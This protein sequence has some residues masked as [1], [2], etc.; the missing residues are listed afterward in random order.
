[1]E[2]DLR[3]VLRCKKQEKA[4]AL[5]QSRKQRG[6]GVYSF[7]LRWTNPKFSG[8]RAFLVAQWKALFK[9]MMERVPEQ[10]RYYEMVR[11]E[12]ACKLYFDLEFNKLLNP[13]VN[14]DS[15]TVKFVDFV[16]AQ[17]TS[18]TGI[19]VA[20]ED[21]LILKSDSDRKYSAHLIVNVDEICFRNNQ[22]CKLFVDFIMASEQSRIF[23]VNTENE[24]KIFFCDMSV[25]SRNRNFRLYKNTKYKKN[26]FLTVAEVDRYVKSH[27][28]TSDEDIF[29]HSLIC[30]DSTEGKRILSD[31]IILTVK[32]T[33]HPKVQSNVFDDLAALFGQV[34]IEPNITERDR[35]MILRTPTPFCRLDKLMAEKVAPYGGRVQ[36]VVHYR[37]T[38]VLLYSFIGYNFCKN[39]GR[40]HRSNKV[41]FHVDLTLPG[42]AQKC[43]D[44]QDC[45][46]YM[47]AFEPI[48]K[49]VAD[50]SLQI[51]KKLESDTKTAGSE[52]SL[53]ENVA[54][55][56]QLVECGTTAKSN[57]EKCLVVDIK[58]RS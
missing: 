5:F 28:L 55:G 58:G 31:D 50:E 57:D 36:K 26:S 37:N 41:Y 35:R 22:V 20:Y 6:E 43:F 34:A 19:N 12:A 14:G 49:I 3:A 44:Y 21:V 8:C 27:G 38:N 32:K 30:L 53:I 48:P 46:G 15:L 18:L 47:S 23:F 52:K 56:F 45:Y 40:N 16:C 2:E 4:I 1:M 11:E 39:R 10:R 17:I 25:Y 13:D 33:L 42:Y 29:Y 51:L 7:E 54:S 24:K 9:L